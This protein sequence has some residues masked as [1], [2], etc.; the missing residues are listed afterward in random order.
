MLSRRNV[1]VK[2]MQ[3]LYALAKDESFD[4]KNLSKEYWKR[5]DSSFELLLFSI[6]NI[7]E[8][9]KIAVEDGEK[10][11]NKHLPT[12][13]D[14]V[15]SAKLWQN[16]MIQ[17]LVESKA[18]AKK[19]ENYYF[20]SKVDKDHY[21]TIYYDF[22][23]EEAYTSFLVNETTKDENL[24]TLLE[25]YRFCRR[26]ELFN[27]IIED[28]FANW[29][30]DKSL[31]I[32]S[33][34][35]ILKGLP[36]DN[37]NFIMDHYPDDETCKEYG[38]LLLTRTFSDDSALMELIKP[39]LENWDAERVATLDLIMIKMAICEF[40][41]CPSIPTKVTLNEYVEL[42]KTYSTSKS[43]EF[44]NGVLDKLG[45]NL[46]AEGKIKK[47]GRGLVDE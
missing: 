16:N 13:I 6:Y 30:D 41:Y 29:E 22:C 33:I 24:E 25:L 32:G 21:K 34:K 9:A 2:V 44:V 1:R 19:F 23:K 28:Q 31:I 8:I 36:S 5:I 42:A 15:F 20:G 26:N 17:T 37:P 18:V 47:E 43:K 40:I 27:E 14:K 46:A 4:P 11:K 35:K 3:V 39:V 10:R 7:I 45:Q 38:E 12:E